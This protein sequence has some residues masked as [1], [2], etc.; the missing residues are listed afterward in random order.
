MSSEKKAWLGAALGLSLLGCG[1]RVNL[2]SERG[3]FEG[4]LA[5]AGRAQA[6]AA[7]KDAFYRE[8]IPHAGNPASSPYAELLADLNGMQAQADAMQALGLQLRGLEKKFDAFAAGRASLEAQDSAAAGQLKA[9]RQDL[10]P[11]DRRMGELMRGYHQSSADFEQRVAQNHISKTTAVALKKEVADVLDRFDHS[12]QDMDQKLADDRRLMS[13]SANGTPP[14][15]QNDRQDI[16]NQMDA[17]LPGLRGASQSLR[18]DAGQATRDLPLSDE[19]WAGPGMDGASLGSI[20]DAEETFQRN[21]SD[22]EAL[23]RR[24]DATLSPGA[25]SP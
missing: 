20:W 23:S 18:F 13:L 11:L 12:V 10:Q 2:A 17:L 6:D 15:L 8:M 14:N 1:G 24:F 7:E 22:F 16:I 3:R 4:P 19:I 21:Q 5:L 25:V 9:L